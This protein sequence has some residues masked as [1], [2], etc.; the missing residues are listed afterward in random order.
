MD[1]SNAYRVPEDKPG[2]RYRLLEG[3][4]KLCRLAG[5]RER[6]LGTPAQTL[7][8]G[9]PPGLAPADA[10]AAGSGA[11][12]SSSRANI[13]IPQEP[14]EYRKKYSAVPLLVTSTGSHDPADGREPA[15]NSLFA[16]GK[17]S[18]A[19]IVQ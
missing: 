19:I 8:E 3:R 17:T 4:G 13:R 11:P 1:L 15:P 16:K 18:V 2:T 9:L 5:P 12:R 6:S 14:A 7:R 10:A